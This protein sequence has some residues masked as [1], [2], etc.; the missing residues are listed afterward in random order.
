MT[1]SSAQKEDINQISKLANNIYLSSRY[2][3]DDNFD[4]HKVNL[5]YKD[6][7]KKSVYGK[8]DDLCLILKNKKNNYLLGFVTI[9]INSDK[10]ASI[11]LIGVNKD[12]QRQGFGSILIKNLFF[13]LYKIKIKKLYVITQ[14]RNISAQRL[15]QK[16]GFIIN[17]TEIWYHKWLN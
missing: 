8:F 12:F 14:G 3:Y 7:L 15:Y 2:Y 10:S 13:Y 5:Y 17:N 16:N 4:K 9:K 6:W 1:F 11:G